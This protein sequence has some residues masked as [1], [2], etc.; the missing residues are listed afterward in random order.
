MTSQVIV[1]EDAYQE[2]VSDLKK[3]KQEIADLKSGAT[4]IELTLQ[5]A[6]IKQRIRIEY[7]KLSELDQE[8][9]SSHIREQYEQGLLDTLYGIQGRIYE[10]AEGKTP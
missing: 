5:I 10:I 8:I 7:V 1:D 2:L 3:Y 9:K 4:V 6:E